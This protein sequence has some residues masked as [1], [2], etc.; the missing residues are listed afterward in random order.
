[1]LPIDDHHAIC[2]AGCAWTHVNW[3][4]DHG[5]LLLVM[6]ACSMIFFRTRVKGR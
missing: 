6:A 3:V 5:G 4:V 2:W 1:M